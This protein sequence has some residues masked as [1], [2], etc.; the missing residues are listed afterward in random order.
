MK[1]KKALIPK[2]KLWI[3]LTLIFLPI[4][5]LFVFREME[6]FQ[7]MTDFIKISR[8]AVC[9]TFIGM[10]ALFLTQWT[11]DDG[12]EM[13][14]QLRLRAVLMAVVTTVGVLL[15]MSLFDLIFD[16]DSSF[17]R[18]FPLMFLILFSQILFFGQQMYKLS[19]EKEDK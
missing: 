2:S 4:L 10:F 5:L 11:K 7:E 12:D 9:I 17:H 16:I 18:G 19:N 13:Y 6:Y 14:M 15:T 8:I 3:S 1:A